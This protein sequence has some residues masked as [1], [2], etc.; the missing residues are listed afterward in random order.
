M[1][2]HESLSM[3]HSRLDKQDTMLREILERMA[4][5]R[6]EHEGVDP[7]ITELVGILKGMK[8]LRSTTL[9]IAAIV[10]AGWAIIVWAKDHVRL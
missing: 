4:E 5:H 6:K 7:S 1:N 8:F 10:G 9:L 2:D 3:I